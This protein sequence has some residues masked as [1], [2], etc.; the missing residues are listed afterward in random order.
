MIDSKRAKNCERC[1]TR[2]MQEKY[3]GRVFDYHNCPFV[4]LENNVDNVRSGITKMSRRPR[5]ILAD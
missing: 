1:N 5:I 4:C 3:L 2:K